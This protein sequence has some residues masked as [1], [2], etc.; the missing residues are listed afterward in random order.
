MSIGSRGLATRSVVGR[1]NTNGGSRSTEGYGGEARLLKSTMP[2]L[3]SLPSAIESHLTPINGTGPY[4]GYTMPLLD[5]IINAVRELYELN[6]LSVLA[7]TQ[8]FAPSLMAAKDKV[9]NIGSIVHRM[10]MA[11]TGPSDNKACTGLLTDH[12]GV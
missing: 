1:F 11:F 8:A 12:I 9:I 10:A 5:A 2:E 3:V 7:V 4:L 6:V